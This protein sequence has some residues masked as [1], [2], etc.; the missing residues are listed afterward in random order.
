MRSCPPPYLLT[1]SREANVKSRP[2]AKLPGLRNSDGRGRNLSLGVTHST[3][4]PIPKLLHTTGFSD[5]PWGWAAPLYQGNTCRKAREPLR[6]SE[7]PSGN[8]FTRAQ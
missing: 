7:I 1:Q 5:C 2:Q 6:P 4:D 3:E 8:G